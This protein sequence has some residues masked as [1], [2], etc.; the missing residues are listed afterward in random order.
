M[1]KSVSERVPDV[2]GVT[3]TP[4]TGKKTVGLGLARRLGYRF[5]DINDVVLQGRLLLP[6]DSSG[7]VVDLARLKFEVRKRIGE[8]KI[9]VVGHLLPAVT[10]KSDVDFTVVLRCS[11]GELRK[12][13]AARG[14]PEHK[15]RG[16]VES[17]MIDLCLGESIKKY[18][19]GKV[20]EFD[21]TGKEAKEV[22]WEITEYFRGSS[23]IRR[24]PIRWLESV[25]PQDLVGL[26]AR[27]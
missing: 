5:L 26:E 12:R 25:K 27:E 2:I 10:R 6:E 21:T 20:A 19:R 7:S 22:V 13:L 1:P 18:G 24:E 16:N 3:G 11:P 17:E 15:I 8:G 14:Y 4:G 9:V 23:S